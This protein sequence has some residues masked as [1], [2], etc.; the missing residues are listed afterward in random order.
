MFLS[1]ATLRNVITITFTTTGRI[2]G[3]F[4][5]EKKVTTTFSGGSLI[6]PKNQNEAPVIDG[7]DLSTC[8]VAVCK[9]V[10]VAGTAKAGR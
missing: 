10:V 8:S 2:L 1:F 5:K 3:R 6:P 4:R 7:F 9:V